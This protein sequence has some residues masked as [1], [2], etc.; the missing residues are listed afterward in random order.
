MGVKKCSMRSE[1]SENDGCE[2]CG[3]KERARDAKLK[4]IYKRYAST[5]DEEMKNNI[6]WIR[7]VNKHS[8]SGSERS[9]E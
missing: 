6:I 8:A 7:I 5:S 3:S 4:K 2:E 9:G 1:R